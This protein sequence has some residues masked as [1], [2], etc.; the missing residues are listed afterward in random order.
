L[1]NVQQ[2]VEKALKAL[3]IEKDLKF[4]RTHSIGELKQILKK[5]KIDIDID[6]DDSDLFDSI[7]MPTKYPIANVLPDFMPDS[8]ICKKTIKIAE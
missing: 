1:Q 2:A 6:D 5:G 4:E 8:K 7:Y 3:V